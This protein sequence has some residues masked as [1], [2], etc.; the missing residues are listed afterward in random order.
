MPVTQ[1]IKTKYPYIVSF[2]T[3]CGG[4]PVIIGTKFT[5]KR[6]EQITTEV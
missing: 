6:I 2:K 5:E 1:K 3:H 4:S